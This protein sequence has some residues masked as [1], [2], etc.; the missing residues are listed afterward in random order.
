MLTER[1]IP[2]PQELSGHVRK[3]SDQM[4]PKGISAVQL[5]STMAKSLVKA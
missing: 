5:R 3:S 2:E 4:R 1:T